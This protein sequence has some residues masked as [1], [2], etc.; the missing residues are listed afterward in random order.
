MTTDLRKEKLHI[1]ETLK[2]KFMVGLKIK[3]MILQRVK[4]QHIDQ[5]SVGLVCQLL[6]SR[7][8]VGA[9]TTQI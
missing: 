1:R 5:N 4:H 7:S 3:L 9:T 6:I 2:F 8:P